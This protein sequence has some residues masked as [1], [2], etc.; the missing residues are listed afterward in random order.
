MTA[1]PSFFWPLPLH[2]Y[3]LVVIDPPWPFVTWSD[4]GQGK[5]ASQHYR[6]MLLSEIKALPVRE[7]LKKDAV[8][9]LWTTAPLL[10]QALAV[11]ESWE[12]AYKTHIVWRKVTRTGKVRMG[13]GFWVRTMHEAVLLG[14]V[15]KPP[16]FTLPSCFDGIAREHSR[17]PAEF[18]SLIGDRTPGLRRAD[19]FARERRD[20][21][22][23]WGDEVDRFTTGALNRPLMFQSAATVTAG[24]IYP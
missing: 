3:D 16:K 18:Y 6:M 5:S 14:T 22:D 24:S 17:K 7:L 11:L 9:F 20:G 23:V 10:P 4:A 13:C 19:L 2:S 15:G 21:W 12:I 1:T 8:V